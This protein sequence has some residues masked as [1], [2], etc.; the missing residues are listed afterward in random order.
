MKLLRRQLYICV[1]FERKDWAGDLK[2]ES[3][4]VWMAFN[5]VGLGMITKGLS[6]NRELK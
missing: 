5:A 4:G 6:I 1:E 2:L 3:H